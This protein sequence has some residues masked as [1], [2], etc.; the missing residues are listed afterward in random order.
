MI[1]KPLS[2]YQ[3]LEQL[4]EGGMATVFKAYDTNL[5]REVTIKII[6]REAFP[7]EQSD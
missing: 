4:G 2:H 5:E 7:P 3:I 1:G 6:C